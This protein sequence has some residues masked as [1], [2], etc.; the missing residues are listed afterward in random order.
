MDKN[1]IEEVG[2]QSL[3]SYEITED[4]DAGTTTLAFDHITMGPYY[5]PSTGESRPIAFARHVVRLLYKYNGNEPI[6]NLTGHRGI[7]P[8]TKQAN[9]QITFVFGIDG[10]SLPT[11]WLPQKSKNG[12]P[13]E[14]VALEGTLP[15]LG[16]ADPLIVK[17][18]NS[19]VNEGIVVDPSGTYVPFGLQFTYDDVCGL[20]AKMLKASPAT[21]KKLWI[22]HPM[23]SIEDA[24]ALVERA[25]A[26]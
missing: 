1:R 16:G 10:S 6:A 4:T 8:V 5:D 13:I 26:L 9:D 12:K 24:V 25:M 3:I 22:S 18:F 20:E 17:Y 15:A 21:G 11:G 2:S 23:S 14:L 7:D 19:S